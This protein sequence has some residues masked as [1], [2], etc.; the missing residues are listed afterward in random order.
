MSAIRRGE[1]HFL[2][3]RTVYD[4]DAQRDLVIIE[5]MP[6]RGRMERFIEPA[7][8]RAAADTEEN[9]HD[10]EAKNGEG[11]ASS[12]HGGDL[13]FIICSFKFGESNAPKQ[14]ET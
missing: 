6:R 1:G 10:C 3:R 14:E 5:R 11:C 4:R 12:R 2:E 7:A 13:L 8:V 9:C